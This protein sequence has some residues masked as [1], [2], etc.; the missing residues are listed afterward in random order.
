MKPIRY[1][2]SLAMKLE[3]ATRKAVERLAKKENLSLGGAARELLDAGIRAK[4]IEC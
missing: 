2:S 3:P 4:G 1:T